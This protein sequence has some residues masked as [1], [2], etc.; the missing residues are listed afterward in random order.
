MGFSD[1]EKKQ[2]TFLTNFTVY[3]NAVARP[4]GHNSKKKKK[5]ITFSFELGLKHVKTLT[6]VL[7]QHYVLIEQCFFTLQF[8][9]V[10]QRV[11]TF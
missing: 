6:A 9:G 1:A 4:V 10:S 11:T 5:V 8:P 2:L 7:Q 3:R